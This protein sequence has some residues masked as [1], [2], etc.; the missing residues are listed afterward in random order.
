VSFET[1]APRFVGQSVERKED[2]RLLTGRG[3]YVDDVVLPRML[4]AAFLRSDVARACV[5][6]IDGSA[7]RALPGVHAVYT[8]ADFAKHVVGTTNPTMFLDMAL[9]DAPPL[10]GPEVHFAGEAIAMVV[11]ETR[12]L[13]ED[14]LELIDVELDVLEPVLDRERAGDDASELVFADRGSNVMSTTTVPNPA[15]E[16]ALA[17]AEHVVTET[18]HQI[19]QAHVPMEPHGIVASW[20]PFDGDLRLWA[21]SQRVHEIK[22]TLSRALGIPDHHIHVTQRDVGGAFGQKGSVRPEEMSTVLAARDLGRPVKWIEDRRENLI[23]GGHARD[24]RV[25]VTMGV[26]RDGTI[27]GVRLEHLENEGA[28][29]TTPAVGALVAMLFP[30]PYE[31]GAVSWSTTAVFTNTGG[32]LPYRGPWNLE[33]LA[34]EQMMDHVARVIGLDPLEFRRRNV[35]SGAAMPYTNASGMPYADIDPA[36]TLAH[37]GSS[38]DY[39]AFRREQ[40]AARAEGRRLGVGI[41]LFIEP[42]ALG[43]GTMMGTEA[44]HV[45]MSLSGKVSVA[46]GTGS[47]GQSTATTMAQIAADELGVDF[48]DVVVTDG[49]SDLAPQ[50]G[51]SGGSRAGVLGGAATHQAASEVRQKIVAIAAHLLEAAPEDLELGDGRVNVR[52]TPDR[53]VTVAEIAHAAYV[54]PAK[55]PPGVGPGLEALARYTTPGITWANA[56]HVCVVEVHDTGLV[57]LLR[58]VVSEDC[59]V[60]INPAV[61]HGQISGG[62]VQG[63]GAALLEQFVYDDAGNPLTTTFMDYLIPTACDVPVLEIGHLDTRAPGPGGYKG[64]G[65]GGMIGAVPAVR[66]AISDALG[67]TVTRP[68]LPSDVYELMGGTQ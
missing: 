49:D 63:I 20:D 7:A 44:A 23:S 37:M 61:V 45:K 65:E 25:T 58:Y 52:G 8:A 3:T 15:V 33:S 12:Y 22:A 16:E 53:G 64:V 34:R 5:T 13:A 66:N 19:R 11:A 24:D 51:G 43:A 39:E 31:M 62:V 35:I 40:A 21:S 1:A 41:S 2:P 10:A 26:D 14:A 57:E 68:V 17:G 6:S 59:G 60:M 30:G 47:H 27:L 54:Q 67:V 36:A 38:F 28:F 46:L 56:C 18:F 32:R 29:P 55:L 48:D 9:P 4:H 50:G 42:T